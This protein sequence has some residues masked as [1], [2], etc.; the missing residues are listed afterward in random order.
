MIPDVI[1]MTFPHDQFIH[2]ENRDH[3]HLHFSGQI[4][5]KNISVIADVSD[6]I[7][8]SF[9]L[10]DVFF[11]HPEIKLEDPDKVVETCWKALTKMDGKEKA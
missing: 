7:N 4:T 11:P 3:S 9:V 1:I 5:E 2:T 6:H 10:N 8:E